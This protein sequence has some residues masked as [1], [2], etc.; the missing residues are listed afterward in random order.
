MGVKIQ[1][2][3]RDVIKD[4]TKRAIPVAVKIGV[5]GKEA[6]KA[7]GKA[8]V[9]DIAAIHEFGLGN[10]PR[11]SWLRDW[12]DLNEAVS[13]EKLRKGYQKVLS[14]QIN[15]ETLATAFGTWAVASIQERIAAGI[16]PALSPE[17]VKRKESS[18]PLIDTGVLRSSITFILE[19]GDM[20]GGIIP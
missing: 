8:T 12:V 18:I 3:G 19:S 10:N 11:R 1:H 13:R 7:H 15:V 5:Q 9:A 2:K 6:G 14:G 17:T 4:I 16:S 20:V